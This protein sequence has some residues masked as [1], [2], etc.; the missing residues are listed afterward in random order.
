MREEERERRLLQ[1]PESHHVRGAS[2]PAWKAP[3]HA[4]RVAGLRYM[5]EWRERN[6]QR[7]PSHMVATLP[8]PRLLAST[9][10]V[11]PAVNTRGRLTEAVPSPHHTCKDS[12]WSQP[13]S[14]PFS[15]SNPPSHLSRGWERL[16]LI[17][18]ENR[19]RRFH[20]AATCTRERESR[21]DFQLTPTFSSLDF[22]DVF[23]VLLREDPLSRP[24]QVV[25]PPPPGE[26]GGI[27]DSFP[28]FQVSWEIRW[29]VGKVTRDW[30]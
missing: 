9:S 8:P 6:V 7:L 3:L 27:V 25:P 20:E 18:L 19:I 2:P 1:V 22:M 16:L 4:G 23:C 24:F 5:S 28:G 12:P 26:G 11:F 10:N 29:V 17:A 13:L 21:D 15:L 14:L 30:E